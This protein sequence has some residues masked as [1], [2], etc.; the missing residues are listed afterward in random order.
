[1]AGL[2][3]SLQQSLE[4]AAARKATPS[5]TP[6]ATPAVPLRQAMKNAAIALARLAKNAR[7]LEAIRDLHGIEILARAMKGDVVKTMARPV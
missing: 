1:M 3:P 4:G 6:R 7:C 2:S 5:A